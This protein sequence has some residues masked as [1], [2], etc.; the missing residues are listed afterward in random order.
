MDYRQKETI[1]RKS[2][3][4][5]CTTK[6]YEM[7]INTYEKY[8]CLKNQEPKEKTECKKLMLEE[9]C[10]KEAADNLEET[11]EFFEFALGNNTEIIQ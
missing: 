8:P 10:G 11:Q 6:I 3:V 7:K 9:L 2:P 1:F 5:K 4:V